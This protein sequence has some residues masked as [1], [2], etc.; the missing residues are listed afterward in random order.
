MKTLDQRKIKV[1]GT[2][3]QALPEDLLELVRA[4]YKANVA[5]NAAGREEEKARKALYARMKEVK[6]TAC[7]TVA[8]VDGKRINLTAEISTPERVAVDVNLLRRLVTEEQFLKIVS[9]SQTSV[10]EEVG[11]AVLRQC[12]V[13][14]TGT[15]NV[16]VKPTK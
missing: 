12:S 11:D 14:T 3:A 8:V 6:L 13:T 5:K 1:N 2:T 15:E 4:T 10:K 16:S 7:Q 9:A